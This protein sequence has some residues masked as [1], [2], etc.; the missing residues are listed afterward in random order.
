MAERDG[1]DGQ[2][3]ICVCVN[4]HLCQTAAKLTEQDGREARHSCLFYNIVD[5]V[6][7]YWY[8]CY[9]ACI[10]L[11]PWHAADR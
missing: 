5:N 10:L 2:L 6:M 11:V 1:V 3:M 9:F 4:A 7:L 8:C